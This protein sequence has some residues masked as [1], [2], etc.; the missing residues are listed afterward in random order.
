MGPILSF[1]RTRPF[2]SAIPIAFTYLK[3]KYG[4]SDDPSL[5]KKGEV[6]VRGSTFS[7]A[8]AEVF[9]PGFFKVAQKLLT[10]DVMPDGKT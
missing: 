6:S 9:E 2:P 3:L 8:R 4:V 7:I 5:A 10:G 1:L